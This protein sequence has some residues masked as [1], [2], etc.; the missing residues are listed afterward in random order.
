MRTTS[1][2][3]LCLLG[4]GLLP[5]KEKPPTTYTVPLPPPPDFSALEWLVGDWAGK[6]L[7]P[8]PPGEVHLN[9]SI[10]LE[11]RFMIFRQDVSLAATKTAPASKESWMG[12]LSADRAASGFILRTF[13]STGFLTRYRVT[14][15]GPRINFHPEGGEQ[16]PPGWLFRRILQK[17]GPHEFT[18]TVQAAPPNK[19]FF[20]YYT[21]KLTRL[22]SP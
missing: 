5:A 17:S 4:S 19:P 8:G 13:S 22:T 6:T 16:P 11:K 20:D 9:V 3:V 21:V 7:A 2:L 14:A 18:E 15:D 1:L 12:I 10:A